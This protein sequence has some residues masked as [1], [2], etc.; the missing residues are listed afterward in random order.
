MVIFLAEFKATR[1]HEQRSQL[2]AENETLSHRNSIPPLLSANCILLEQLIT[3]KDI[4]A[5]T[6]NGFEIR[7]EVDFFKDFTT[8][9]QERDKDERKQDMLDAA[10]PGEFPGESFEIS[11]LVA[12]CN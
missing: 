6:L 9:F 12:G 5:S 7:F 10:A 8:S 1:A 2:E 3:E 11:L 4:A